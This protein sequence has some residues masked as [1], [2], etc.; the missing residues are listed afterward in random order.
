M[1]VRILLILLLVINAC[2]G[3][4]NSK[5]EVD[6]LEEIQGNWTLIKMKNFS[7]STFQNSNNTPFINIK[8]KNITGNNG[9]NNLFSSLKYIKKNKLEFTVFGE[10]KMMCPDMKIPDNFSK[11]ISTVKSYQIEGNT[12]TF[13]DENEVVLTFIKS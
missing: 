9:C 12:M 4:S 7:E 13:L 3:S 1:K 6:F 10:T 5:T 11:Y 8:E 2:G